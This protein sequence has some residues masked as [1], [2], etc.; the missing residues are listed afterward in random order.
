MNGAGKW[1]LDWLCRKGFN[2]RDTE[3]QLFV[4]KLCLCV[5]VVKLRSRESPTRRSYLPPLPP[6]TGSTS[7]S[8]S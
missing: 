7:M 1:F 3:A 2:H 8:A 6:V 4:L 5:S